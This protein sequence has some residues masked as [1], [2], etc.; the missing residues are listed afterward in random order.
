MDSNS[1]SVLLLLD[2]SVTFDTND[3]GVLRDHHSVSGLALA[4]LK[5]Y[6]SK[7]TQC[8]SYN[9][10]TSPFSDVKYGETQ[11]SVPGPL[12]FSISPLGH[13]ISSVG[14]NL[15]IDTSLIK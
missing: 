8:V 13:I 2:V 1:T 14:I 4:W 12:L 7:R 10:I 5:S 3:C 6:L 15:N 11:G 9:N